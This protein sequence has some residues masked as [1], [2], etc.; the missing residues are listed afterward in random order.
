MKITVK[1]CLQL[2][3]FDKAEVVAASS[4]LDRIV[5]KVS[6]LEA[7][8]KQDV[9][10]YCGAK[11]QM[12][13]TSFFAMRSDEEAQCSAI[14][15]L[16]ENG[17]AALVI[18]HVGRVVKRISRRV[19]LTA[20]RCGLPLII[21]DPEMPFGMGDVIAQV[22]SM[23]LT[24]GEDHESSLVSNTVYHLLN[25]E[26]Y[27]SFPEAAKAAALSNDF[28]LILLSEEFN[29]V[30]T[31]ETRHRTTIAE[32]IRLGR[33]RDVDK[34]NAVYTMIDVHGVLT[35]WG[36]VTIQG[37]KFYMFIV[38]NEDSYTPAEITRLAEIIELAMG[39][40]SY[41][42]EH[43]S[44]AELI[45]ALRRGNISLAY[46]MKDDA[47]VDT[48]KIISVFFGV[49]LDE[50]R[51]RTVMEAF[52][53]HPHLQ[54]I[55]I[56]E[57][58]E[59]CGI[60]LGSRGA[61]D[62]TDCIQV[63]NTLKGA[64]KQTVLFHVT[65]IDGLEGT[66]EAYR[67]IGESWSFAR[68]IYPHKNVFSKYELT[69]VSNCIEIRMNGGRVEK[70]YTSLL[71]PFLNGRVKDRQLLETL[72]IFVLDAGMNNSRT[73]KM[74]KLHTNTI[75]YRLKRINEMLGA[76]ISGNRVIPGLTIALALRRLEMVAV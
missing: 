4:S 75:Q 54:I 47:G 62:K 13:F 1:D 37:S 66:V 39:M 16:A 73:A 32:A 33:K 67:L 15:A 48:D 7:V 46:S 2:A 45:K 14:E 50:P 17:N 31:V 57:E 58:N 34:E 43:D 25:F 22:S 41:T 49:G 24:G 28:Q 12:M 23:L 76:E 35:Y 59:T 3:A 40:W 27:T 60:I 26:K 36:P 11:D 38:D 71:D 18:F 19:V 63:Y 20:E 9:A 42:P 74:M 21:M 52:E 8:D 72:T 56:T 30:L 44:R 55:S 70:N 10:A 53:K 64:L 61:Q 68:R 51:G 5:K 6:V 29:P 69:M 65:D